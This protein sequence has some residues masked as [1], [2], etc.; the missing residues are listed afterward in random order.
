MKR[1]VLMTAALM[2]ALTAPAALAQAPSD[3][4]KALALER[5]EAGSQAFTEGR[6]KDAIDIFLAGDRIV[7]NAAFAFNIGLAYEKMG[8]DARALNWTREYLRR[9]PDAEDR[10]EALARIAKLEHALQAKGLQQVTVLSTP[11][12]A[13]VIVD[14]RPVGVTP[15]TGEIPP[16]SHQIRAQLAG[17]VDAVTELQLTPERASDVSLTLVEAP[18]ASAPAGPSAPAADVPTGD[19]ISG[20]GIGWYTWTALGVGAASFGVTLALE[21]MR[22]SAADDAIDAETQLDAA[23]ELAR[24]EDLQLGA[25]VMVGV[26]AVSTALGV[27]LLIVDLSSAGGASDA[28]ARCHRGECGFV[29][30]F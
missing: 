3:E 15:W 23:A 28:T 6:Y 8:D 20:G 11:G 25:R 21:V 27:A 13:T 22:A 7:A 10:G 19:E 17:H 4:A 1:V 14:G 9:K 2:A 5:Y 24:A 29:V 12:G 16:G 30:R 26:A 18:V